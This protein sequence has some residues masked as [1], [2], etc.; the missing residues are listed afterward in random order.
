MTQ[1]IN[2]PTLLTRRIAWSVAC[3]LFLLPL[4]TQAHWVTPTASDP[5]TAEMPCHQSS[6]SVQDDACQNCQEGQSSLS[7]DCCDLAVPLTLS[8]EYGLFVTLHLH[9]GI[10]RSPDTAEPP[11]PLSSSLYRPPIQPLV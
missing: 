5:V 7:C 8:L 1:Q 3:L 10:R 9:A 11:A 2:R 4:L 6:A